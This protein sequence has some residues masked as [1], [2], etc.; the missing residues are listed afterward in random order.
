MTK[1]ILHVITGLDVGGAESVLSQVCLTQS[2]FTHVVVSLSRGGFFEGKLVENGISVHRLGIKKNLIS[3]VIGLLQLRRIIKIEKADVIQSWMYHADFFAFVASFGFSK[4]PL[5]WSIRNT[6][7]DPIASGRMTS[8]LVIFLGYL[9]RLRF[10]EIIT[11]CAYTAIDVHASRGYP[12][13]KFIVIPNGV[14]CGHFRQLADMRDK[15][16]EYYRLPARGVRAGGR[17]FQIGFVGRFHAQ[18][19]IPLLL[20]AFADV[21]IERPDCFLACAGSGIDSS[22]VKLRN[23][24]RKSNLDGHIFLRGFLSDVNFFLNTLDVLVLPSSFG[25]AFPN[26]L[27]EAMACGVPCIASDVGD[28]RFIIDDTGWIVRPD[29][30]QALADAIVLAHDES[31][32]SEKWAE[33]KEKCRARV[34]SKYSIETM[35]ENYMK[36]WQG[37][38]R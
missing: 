24:I 32:E 19:N 29:S 30:R 10:V 33:R 12:R 36:L 25:E 34:E 27:A 9:A 16:R 6:T 20:K 4:I 37:E 35:I 31:A 23:L 28:S 8:R 7:L 2:S 1:K 14:D 22:N 38:L 13:E 11:T 3:V 18:K 15:L 26:V 17:P 21:R 5:V